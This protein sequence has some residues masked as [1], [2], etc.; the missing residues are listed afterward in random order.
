M[1]E[2]RHYISGMTEIKERIYYKKDKE[3]NRRD[4][5]LIKIRGFAGQLEIMYNYQAITKRNY[6][7]STAEQG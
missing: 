1:Y 5:Y 3:E 2:T 6:Y 7:V 4:V